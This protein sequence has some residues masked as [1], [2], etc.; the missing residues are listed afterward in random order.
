MDPSTPTPS[1]PTDFSLPADWRRTPRL[2]VSAEAGSP[3]SLIRVK[4]C[5]KC[6]S[7]F[8]LGHS[9]RSPYYKPCRCGR[10]DIERKL[11]RR[12]EWN[13]IKSLQFLERMPKPKS[14]ASST[15][16]PSTP[17]APPITIQASF[18]SQKM[19]ITWN[20]IHSQHAFLV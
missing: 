18:L 5:G 16:L 8:L 12:D 4:R 9:P 14:Q 13:P 19:H 3:L 6:N 17:V 15:H 20:G 11:H 10:S 1:V 7:N 2:K